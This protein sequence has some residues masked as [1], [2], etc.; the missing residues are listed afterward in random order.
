[1]VHSRKNL[2]ILRVIVIDLVY[3]YNLKISQIIPCKQRLVT[4]LILL[5][6][7]QGRF[8]LRVI[9]LV[10]VDTISRFHRSS[11]VDID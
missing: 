8:P 11:C 7:V 9:D 4:A 10:Y 6:F 2:I 3:V 1:M 5:W